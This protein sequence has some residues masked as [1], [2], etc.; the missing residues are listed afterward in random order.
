MY[1]YYLGGAHNFASDRAAAQKVIAALPATPAIA[2]ANRAYLARAVQF[3]VDAGVRQ[4]LDVGSGIPTRGNVHEIAQAAAPDAKVVYVDVD[5]VAVTHS[6]ALLRGN[7]RATAVHDD[8]LRPDRFLAHPDLRGLL[9]LTEPVGLLLVSVLHFIPDDGNPHAA[10]AQLREVLSPSSYLA[11]SHGLR[12]GFDP[13]AAA[14][15]RDVYSGTRSS[16][17][18]R[19]RAEIARFFTGFDLVEP[20]L[21]DMTRWRPDP[22]GEFQASGPG[23][24]VGFLA[25]VAR[26]P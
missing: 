18:L 26:K 7:D 24:G 2:S 16:A 14:T 9:D 19:P 1:D 17:S 10:V 25:G 4:F 15:V 20:G 21:V 12:E 23:P 6:L 8:L 3:L 5:P 22:A 11:I 13:D